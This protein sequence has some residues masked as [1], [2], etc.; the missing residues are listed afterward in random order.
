MMM[1]RLLLLVFVMTCVAASAETKP[2]FDRG[3]AGLAGD[4]FTEVFAA[5]DRETRGRLESGDCTTGEGK[6]VDFYSFNGV[7]GQVVEFMVR[8]LSPTYKQPV[9]T[10]ISPTGT[11]VEEPYVA[12]GNP[13]AA[14]SGATVYYQLTSTGKWDIAVSSEDLFATGDYV[15][16]VYCNADN[17]PSEPRECVDQYLLC[18]QTGIWNLGADSC[19]FSTG[20]KAYHA[21]WIYGKKD[22]VLRIEQGALSFT[23]LFGVYDENSK[24]LRSSTRD[25]SV[26]ARATFRVPAT[27]WY[28][29]A[30]TTEE[31]NQGGEYTIKIDCSGSGCTWPYLVSDTPNINV[32]RRGD[33]AIVPFDVNAVGGFTTTLLDVNDQPVVTVSTPTTSITTPPVLRPTT[34]S[35]LFAN[36]CGEWISSPFQVAPEPT[37]R[38]AVRK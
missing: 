18:G 15:L 32:R 24:L 4:C 22:D 11:F 14:T 3:V 26:Y 33:Q 23:P 6:R 12:G 20:S 16:H 28:Y 21:W 27:G 30:T 8:P 9:I 13:S 2:K 31:S 25:S 10:L 17:T 5:C 29:V 7:A 34:Y 35:L 38:R 1:R 37:R 36:A 19:R